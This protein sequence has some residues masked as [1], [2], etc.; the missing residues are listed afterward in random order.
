MVSDDQCHGVTRPADTQPCDNRECTGVWVLG[1]WSPVSK[2]IKNNFKILDRINI[3]I[4][5]ETL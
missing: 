4:K 3:A 5:S 1:E 2:T